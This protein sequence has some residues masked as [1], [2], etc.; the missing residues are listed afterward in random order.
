M[1]QNITLH[2]IRPYIFAR[3]E[4]VDGLNV[5][6]G[7]NGAGKTTIL[8]SMYVLATTKSYK[9]SKLFDLV[10]NQTPAGSITS[11]TSDIETLK[12]EIEPRKHAFSKNGSRVQRTSDFLNSARVV[13]L[14]PEHQE[15]ISGSAE[16]RRAFLDHLLCQKNPLLLD[17]FKIYR[18]TLKQKQALLK[19]NLSMMDY[20]DQVEPWNIKL[21]ESGEQIRRLRLELIEL[22]RPRIQEEYQS[23]SQTQDWVTIDYFQKEESMP[24]QLQKLEFQ[25]YKIKRALVGPH[26]D[27]FDIK[28]RN[29]SAATIASQGEKASALLALKFSEIEHLANPDL[30]TLLLD[31]VGVTLDENRRK[32]LFERLEKL[33]PQTLITTPDPAICHF[34][35]NRGA[36]IY[37][38]VIENSNHVFWR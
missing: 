30:P 23:I 5:L 13:V 17:L 38:K 10:S 35:Q 8:E 19:Q 18:K 27:D 12:V 36:K 20:K 1:F 14:A 26:R 4:F 9:A 32:C 3:A 21:I 28:L 6:F 34:A 25:E 15:L 31:D 16:K 11:E 2:H 33:H 22:L 29:Q 7:P 24:D 37:E